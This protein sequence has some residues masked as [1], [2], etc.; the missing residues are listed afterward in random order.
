MYISDDN[1]VRSDDRKRVEEYEKLVL[2]IQDVQKEFDERFIDSE[3][4][5]LIQIENSSYSRNERLEYIVSHKENGRTPDE[6]LCTREDKII[7][8][9]KDMFK[10]V[11]IVSGSIYYWCK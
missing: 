8:A 1:K 10:P 6:E 3:W 11:Q 7:D 2:I 4:K 9:I 5:F